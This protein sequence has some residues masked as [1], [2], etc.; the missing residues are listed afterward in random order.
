MRK[1]K[2]KLDELAV[3]SF[4]ITGE[5]KGSGTVRAKAVTDYDT[6]RGQDT[7][8]GGG[9]TCADSC[10]GVCGS[11]FCATIDPSCG[12]ETCIDSC[13]NTGC[14]NCQQ[15][16]NEVNTCISPCTYTCTCVC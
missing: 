1:L 10:D 7:C 5:M 11:Y 6:C 3:E 2:L 4:T 15:S 16:I 14:G 8:P 9:N 12:E 13:A